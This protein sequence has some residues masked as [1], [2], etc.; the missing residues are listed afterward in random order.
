MAHE[1]GWRVARAAGL[2]HVADLRDLWSQVERVPERYAT[3]YYFDSHDRRERAVMDD[4]ALVVANTEPAARA[5]RDKYP[6]H[7]DRVVAVMNGSDPI[8]VPPAERDGAFIL[9]YAGSIYLDRDPGAVFAAAG[10][11]VR[12]LA[13]TPAHLRFEFCSSPQ[14]P[15]GRPLVDVAADYGLEGHVV[16]HGFRPHREVLQR[17]AA[18]TMLVSLPQ[19][20]HMAVPSKIFEYAQFDAWLLALAESG[21]ATALVLEGTEADVVDPKDAVGIEA[22]LRRRYAQFAAGARPAAVGRD[23]RFSRRRQAEALLGRL[24]SL[25]AR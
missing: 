10:R 9:F 2:P 18:S 14:H 23:G 17:M 16:V 24:E 11:L 7:A 22:V 5:L 21:S 25:A 12:E 8:D 3:R 4:A 15:S 6:R 20:S 1:A 19:D 13:L